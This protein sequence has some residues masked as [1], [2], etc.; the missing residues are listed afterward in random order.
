MKHKFNIFQYYRQARQHA[1][2]GVYPELSV[3]SDASGAGRLNY[4]R[5]LSEPPSPSSSRATTPAPSEH[6]SV[7]DEEEDSVDSEAEV[8]ARARRKGKC[9]SGFIADN[10]Y[11]SKGLIKILSL[12]QK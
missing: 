6:G 4:P 2:H 5:P 12:K 9:F 7:E 11:F 1:L 3:E 10:S 8:N